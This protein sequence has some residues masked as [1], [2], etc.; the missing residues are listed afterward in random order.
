ME[1][2]NPLKPNEWIWWLKSTNHTQI[3]EISNRLEKTFIALTDRV[4]GNFI[5]IYFLL[6]RKE[7]KKVEWVWFGLANFDYVLLT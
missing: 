3:I 6:V 5:F 1:E 4:N 2:I 7:M